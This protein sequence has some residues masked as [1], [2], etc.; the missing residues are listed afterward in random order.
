MAGFPA[1]FV[2]CESGGRPAILVEQEEQE[3]EEEQQDNWY[4]KGLIQVV[5]HAGHTATAVTAGSQ[6]GL[7]GQV[8]EGRS[9]ARCWE[10]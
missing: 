6:K 9:D 7:G 1:R 3:E 10:P 2:A 8:L 4:S 5:T